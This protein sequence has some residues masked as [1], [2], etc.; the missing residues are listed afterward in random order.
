MIPK[1]D[2]PKWKKFL[3]VRGQEIQTPII[4]TSNE[5]R[6]KICSCLTLS[7]EATEEIVLESKKPSVIKLKIGKE[8][9]RKSPKVHWS[10]LLRNSVFGPFADD[11]N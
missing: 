2:I 3:Y 4:L 7:Y 6:R 11:F 5:D 8:K 10:W 9:L 1:K